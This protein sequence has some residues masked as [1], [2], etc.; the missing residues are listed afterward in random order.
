MHFKDG[1]FRLMQLTDIHWTE[2]TKHCPKTIKTIKEVIRIEKPQLVVITGDVVTGQPAREGW[3]SII[4]IFDDLQQPFVVAMGNHDPEYLSRDEMYKLLL[5]SPYYVGKRGKKKLTG[6]GN[7]IIPIYGEKKPKQ[8]EALIYCFDSNDYLPTDKYGHYDWIHNDQIQWYRKQSAK[9]TKKNDGKPLPALACFHIPV[10][11]Y[12]AMYKAGNYLG[13]FKEEGIG[14]P[15][16][17][18]GLF[19]AFIEQGDVMGVLAGHDHDSDFIGLHYGL[20]LAYGRV[21]GWEAYG[22]M[23]RGCRMFELY[24]GEKRFDSWVR[25]PTKK[26]DVF[27]YPSGLSSRD[28]RPEALHPAIGLNLVG[29]KGLIASYFEGNF[30]KC[31]DLDKA[32]PVISK[33]SPNFSIK[34]ARAEDHFGYIFSGYI[35]V[36][37]TA[38]YKFGVFSD[39]GAVLYI[40][41]TKIVD[42]DGG[43][44]ARLAEGKA[45][46]T[47]GYHKIDLKY[48]DD[49]MGQEL[50]VMISSRFLDE[51]PIPNDWLVYPYYTK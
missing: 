16:I 30:Q 18:S 44:S 20:A 37:E 7:C 25:T 14:S 49:Y 1:K 32:K 39:D 19:N 34:Q 29:G 43:H 45:Y 6:A 35:K 17:N 2:G 47:K 50:K 15:K 3:H 24:E 31:S 9:L 11:E 21:S 13:N 42:N 38:V 8:K 22:S 26:E 4:K 51:R 41:S 28:E 12:E 36:P 48:F 10:P 27:Y 33:I 5:K 46:L 40:D 23:E